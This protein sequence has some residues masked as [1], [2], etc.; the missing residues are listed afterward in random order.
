MIG[1]II[2]VIIVIV[3]ALYAYHERFSDERIMEK[4]QYVET[5][6][7]QDKYEAVSVAPSADYAYATVL[8]R[9]KRADGLNETIKKKYRLVTSSDAVKD[10]ES[11][12]LL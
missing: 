12:L 9:V 3:Y 4:A 11:V 6:F 8:F 1:I 10:G 5:I 2:F 7:S